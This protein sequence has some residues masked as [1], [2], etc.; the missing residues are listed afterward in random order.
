M[1]TRHDICA[2]AD[3]PDPALRSFY[4]GSRR[5][6][7]ARI[8]AEVYALDSVCPHWS[9]LLDEGQ[10]S[11]TRREVICPWHRFRFDLAS[12]ACVASNLRPPARTFPVEIVKGRVVVTVD[13]ADSS[14]INGTSEVTA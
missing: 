12:G 13:E 4:V 1:V 10:L 7:V 14:Q 9:G 2:L 8:A 11:V 5:I 6:A 3:L